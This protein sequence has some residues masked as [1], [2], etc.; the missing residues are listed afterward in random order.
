MAD[1]PLHEDRLNK[2]QW[3]IQ[4]IDG[5]SA[6]VKAIPEI[7]ENIDKVKGKLNELK[8]KVKEDN[9]DT[10]KK[11]VTDDLAKLYE[12]AQ[13][14]K[15]GLENQK[16][17]DKVTL[18]KKAIDELDSDVRNVPKVQS[19]IIAIWKIIDEIKANPTIF[20]ARKWEINDLR[21]Q[22]NDLNSLIVARLK[23]LKAL[24]EYI[25][26]LSPDIAQ[27]I[28]IKS[29]VEEIKKSIE[30]QRGN[31]W[32]V[33]Y[34][35]DELK[36]IREKLEVL[37][38]QVKFLDSIKKA[39]P[40]DLKDL[41]G[42]DDEDR[43]L[44]LVYSRTFANWQNWEANMISCLRN[45]VKL[46]KS[47]G[48]KPWDKQTFFEAPWSTKIDKPDIKEQANDVA[49]Y[50]NEY[51]TTKD[52]LLTL[53]KEHKK[54]LEGKDNYP[55]TFNWR[56]M[57]SDD[58]ALGI[59]NGKL[60]DAVWVDDTYNFS[61]PEDKKE[62]LESMM[63]L[64]PLMDQIQWDADRLNNLDPNDASA[65][66]LILKIIQ[67]STY[68]TRTVSR[69]LTKVGYAL[70]Y[71][72]WDAMSWKP[73]WSFE[74]GKAMGIDVSWP[75][76]KYLATLDMLNSLW[77]IVAM[78][79]ATKFLKKLFF[80]LNLKDLQQTIK[81]LKEWK[82]KL[83]VF[84]SYKNRV[85]ENPEDL[86]E[87]SQADM[88]RK[89]KAFLQER[90]QNG[91]APREYLGF[92]CDALSQTEADRLCNFIDGEVARA[93]IRWDYDS[94]RTGEL[95]ARDRKPLSDSV[96][97]KLIVATVSPNKWFINFMCGLSGKSAKDTFLWR[98]FGD[99]LSD[100][101]R[102]IKLW[103]VR[104]IPWSIAD[105]T[106]LYTPKDP[107]GKNLR[108]FLWKTD[109]AWDQLGTEMWIEISQPDPLIEKKKISENIQWLRD[110]GII[111]TTAEKVLYSETLKNL[112]KN[113][114]ILQSRLNYTLLSLAYVCRWNMQQPIDPEEER[115]FRGRF[116]EGTIPMR[117]LTGTEKTEMGAL[118]G[119][120]NSK[121]QD[122]F[123]IFRVRA[124]LYQPDATQLLQNNLWTTAQNALD[125][126][127]NDLEHGSS[128][129]DEFKEEYKKWLE[130]HAKEV[131]WGYD[132]K[133]SLEGYVNQHNFEAQKKDIKSRVKDG[134]ISDLEALKKAVNKEIKKN[135]SVTDALRDAFIASIPP[136]DFI[137]YKMQ[138]GEPK[139]RYEAYK[140]YQEL[141]TSNPEDH[142]RNKNIANT[143]INTIRSEFDG[144]MRDFENFIKDM[145]RTP[146]EC[147]EKLRVIMEKYGKTYLEENGFSETAKNF[148]VARN[149][150]ILWC[151]WYVLCMRDAEVA[152]KSTD[153]SKQYEA[154]ERFEKNKSNVADM[155][156][157]FVNKI[158]SIYGGSEASWL[159]KIKKDLVENAT[160][161]VEKLKTDYGKND[162]S[163]S[164]FKIQKDSLITKIWKKMYEIW[165]WDTV[166]INY[167]KARYLKISNDW[168]TEIELRWRDSTSAKQLQWILDNGEYETNKQGDPTLGTRAS[169]A[170]GKFLKRNPNWEA[171]SSPSTESTTPPPPSENPPTPP[172]AAPATPGT[173]ATNPDITTEG[174][175]TSV[176]A[177]I[178][179]NVL[180]ISNE[181][182]TTALGALSS[183]EQIALCETYRTKL[184]EI[185]D[186]ERNLIDNRRAALK[187]L[188]FLATKSKIIGVDKA[189][190]IKKYCEDKET[191][192]QHLE[193][194]IEDSSKNAIKLAEKIR[195]VLK[196]KNDPKSQKEAI[197]S[198][199]SDE[200]IRLKPVQRDVIDQ[201]LP[202]NG[203]EVT[204]D[205][206]QTC[207]H[208]LIETAREVKLNTGS[209]AKMQ[210][211]RLA[212]SH[213]V[214]VSVNTHLAGLVNESV[215]ANTTVDITHWKR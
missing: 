70:P 146:E 64:I 106:G 71:G 147:S 125:V 53:A 76:P 30:T 40:K 35:T 194:D 137:I 14:A 154:I 61:S 43:R 90:A 87:E 5:F 72:I 51:W 102:W 187:K 215:K 54:M 105:L 171:Q 86:I 26:G 44:L 155:W 133:K 144:D 62:F 81:N 55:T 2:L 96:K 88:V 203:N 57:D 117:P 160:A 3:A 31:I 143:A 29:L 94:Q 21:G 193:N 163:E 157:D 150:A 165:W 89:M 211:T 122:A 56:G 39:N 37:I 109:T 92:E 110:S 58:N 20:D 24:E 170:H 28:W 114:N 192:I 16:N 79:S 91:Y 83:N 153:P 66:V 132:P 45:A 112:S 32:A 10:I 167:R 124:L 207:V 85:N 11:W 15:K 46:D 67:Y 59:W 27:D 135:S 149:V 158:S 128:N 162:V 77:M 103:P 82:K 196:G 119:K 195:D 161:Q 199:L 173:P 185:A 4:A 118:I 65:I 73:F 41:E 8:S 159:R 138:N 121:S 181:R 176:R 145:S 189:K 19:K 164:E 75:V 139:A 148:F 179:N 206:V 52:I 202:D 38:P 22:I 178:Q 198:L 108:L 78:V 214:I 134:S 210:E 80:W 63:E 136:E 140:K 42:M 166:E 101:A 142:N 9:Y 141:K 36:K 190:E 205:Q 174:L 99:N 34:N 129:V 188:S 74:D 98:T 12:D 48:K 97:R 130:K 116:L 183:P 151:E 208:R 23:K 33:D 152:I 69:V 212:N 156:G 104:T 123:D 107:D 209:E 169:D 213:N 49:E 172:E 180:W 177:D 168:L 126:L 131:P 6:E 1:I 115:E 50:A 68:F 186:D 95:Q 200:S 93:V 60:W 113:K 201:I 7:K 182:F 18:V 127:L 100:F 184:M 111:D 13:E 191:A 84:E 120:F 25:D 197:R 175:V 47:D 204:S 17:I